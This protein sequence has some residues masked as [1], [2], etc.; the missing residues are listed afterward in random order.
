MRIRSVIE[1]KV[2]WSLYI[3][4]FVCAQFATS[5]LTYSSTNEQVSY[6]DEFCSSPRMQKQSQF[7]LK[8]KLF[9]PRSSETI[10]PL[11]LSLSLSGI[12]S[13]SQ[14]TRHKCSWFYLLLFNNTSILTSIT[15]PFTLPPLHS[16]PEIIIPNFLSFSSFILYFNVSGS[17]ILYTFSETFCFHFCFPL[18]VLEP[19][20]MSLY[21]EWLHSFK[22]LH[23]T[24]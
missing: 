21:R 10:I 2:T 6:R 19:L 1:N 22:W 14:D 13:S 15:S 17:I 5:F 4:V 8:A 18:N 16:F 3:W 20:P 24:P 23:S 12:C 7:T 11:K 9:L